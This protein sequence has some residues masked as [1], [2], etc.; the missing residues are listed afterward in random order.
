MAD[1]TEAVRSRLVAHAG[2]TALIGTR[3]WFYML[4]QDPTLPAVTVQQ[5]SA[6][7]PSAMGSDVGKAEGRIQ[8]RA[9]AANR[10]GVKALA[11]QIRAALQRFSGTV[12]ST[13]IIDI[14]FAN[15]RE[16]Y[17]ADVKVWTVDQDWMVW[18]S[19]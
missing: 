7:R 9:C 8:T 5:I 18:W 12:A 14:R 6:V 10:A 17:E 13:E 1:V 3:A 4:P 19:E 2:T 16:N 15:E 11:E